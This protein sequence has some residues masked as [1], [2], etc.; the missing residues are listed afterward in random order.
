MHHRL[1]P[2]NKQ[3]RKKK[4][5]AVERVK[6]GGAGQRKADIKFSGSGGR[7]SYLL[8]RDLFIVYQVKDKRQ[9]KKR[10]ASV[11]QTG[12]GRG[13]GGAYSCV[14]CLSHLTINHAASLSRRGRGRGGG[15][16]IPCMT[17]GLRAI[18]GGNSRT[19]T[20]QTNSNQPRVFLTHAT[21]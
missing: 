12:R 16:V 8:S 6:G 21:V 7:G 18:D 10:R 17:V 9:Q 13:G 14:A 4:K 19:P 20:R 11:G 15:G 3:K 1:P 2:R 5:L